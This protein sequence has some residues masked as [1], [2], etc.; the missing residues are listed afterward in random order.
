M[1]PQCSR[2][3][4]LGEAACVVRVGAIPFA[5]KKARHA[6]FAMT[7]DEAEI[8]TIVCPHVRWVGCL[9]VV[10]RK[11]LR[12]PVRGLYAADPPA[13]FPQAPGG[14]Q[15]IRRY[16]R[17][18]KFRLPLTANP[19]GAASYPRRISL[20]SAI[21]RDAPSQAKRRML[22][23]RRSGSFAAFFRKTE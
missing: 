4:L 12:R 8:R 22:T 19:C 9:R 11:T 16:S 7:S 1:A 3:S 20:P 10:I 5:R 21:G 6:S 14:G 18:V 15:Q 17:K 2:F 23:H 13:W